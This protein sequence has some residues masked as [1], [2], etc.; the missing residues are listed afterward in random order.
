MYNHGKRAKTD[1]HMPPELNPERIWLFV[2]NDC[3]IMEPMMKLIFDVYRCSWY[4]EKI[5]G[6][7]N[8]KAHY[9]WNFWNRAAIWV[10]LANFSVALLHFEM[11]AGKSFM[12][13]CR[14]RFMS[15]ICKEL[16]FWSENAQVQVKK[17]SDHHKSEILLKFA[18]LLS[19]IRSSLNF[20][21]IAIL[22]M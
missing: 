21:T 15:E 17:G 18:I 3:R 2:G 1:K 14:E 16:R 5:Y 9:L 6:V 19:Q 11:T 10:W 8:F 4:E 7:E 13:L 12:G 22:R 20:H